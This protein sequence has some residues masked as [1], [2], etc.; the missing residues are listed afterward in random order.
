MK[1]LFYKIG[2]HLIFRDFVVVCLLFWNSISLHSPCS[3]GTHCGRPSWP[4]ACLC[5]QLKGECNHT[6]QTLSFGFQTPHRTNSSQSLSGLEAGTCKT[7]T[8]ASTSS[9]NPTK[10]FFAVSFW[11]VCLLLETG[12]HY[13][14]LELCRPGSPQLCLCPSAL[15]LKACAPH[16]DLYI[17]L[18]LVHPSS[19]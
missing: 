6:Q 13:I 8:K 19:P 16:P 11:F 12:S 9:S 14:V 1:F 5:L 18:S 3:P 17:F 4:W 7:V 2:L 10:T 15:I